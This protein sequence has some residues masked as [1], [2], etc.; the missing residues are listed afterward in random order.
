MR[1]TAPSAETKKKKKTP[2]LNRQA[3]L[4]DMLLKQPTLVFFYDANPT[5]AGMYNVDVSLRKSDAFEFG[6]TFPALMQCLLSY[7]RRSESVGLR[8]G[9]HTLI[10]VAKADKLPGAKLQV[11]QTFSK[12]QQQTGDVECERGR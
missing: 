10:T 2:T 9:T 6:R 5:T 4:T 3:A 11:K 12:Q 8:V 1:G 7:Y